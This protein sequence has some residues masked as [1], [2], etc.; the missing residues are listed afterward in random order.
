MLKRLSFACRGATQAE[1]QAR[2]RSRAGSVGAVAIPDEA[3]GL[4]HVQDHRCRGAW[5]YDVVSEVWFDGSRRRSRTAGAER[6]LLRNAH[7][8]RCTGDPTERPG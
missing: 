3:K 8:L 5:P 7:V 1:F 4:A 2:W 6:T